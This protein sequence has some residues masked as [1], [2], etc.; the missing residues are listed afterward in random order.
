MPRK[1]VKEILGFTIEHGVPFAEFDKSKN[2]WVR[3]VDA[4]EIG[5][6]TVLKTSGDVVSFR[7]T[8]KR[9]GFKCLS[10]AIRDKD[11][12]ATNDIRVWKLK[13]EN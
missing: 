10:R 8:C 3:L 12:N 6:S 11:G 5:D 7:M 2:K 9:Q 1:V 4:M 13:N